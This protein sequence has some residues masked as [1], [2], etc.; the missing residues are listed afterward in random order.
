MSHDG[1]SDRP[2]AE[3]FRTELKAYLKLWRTDRFAALLF[4]FFLVAPTLVT[5]IGWL[6]SHSSNAKLV[7]E[8]RRLDSDLR[9]IQKDHEDMNR[10]VAP[11]IRQAAKEFPGE[12]INQSLKRIIERLDADRP[13]L[14]PLASFTVTFDIT[15]KTP[16]TVSSTYTF[17]GHFILLGRNG[18]VLSIYGEHQWEVVVAEPQRL[19][20]FSATLKMAD[21]EPANGKSIHS[22]AAAESVEIVTTGIAPGSQIVTGK[23]IITM[24]SSIRIE[25]PIPAQTMVGKIISIRDLTLFKDRI[26]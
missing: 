3:W 13:A 21:T 9:M 8:N 12:E 15:A 10:I 16:D 24:N 6:F 19:S 18:P 23:A 26:Q 4:T 20:H 1:R 25:L 11:L 5:G 14:K 2:R 17:A 22:L 7:E